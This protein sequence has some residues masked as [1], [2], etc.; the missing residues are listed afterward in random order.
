MNDILLHLQND[1]RVDRNSLLSRKNKIQRLISQGLT[2]DAEDFNVE[3]VAAHNMLKLNIIEKLFFGETPDINI[4]CPSHE[5]FG[6]E[7]KR[8]R[9]RKEDERD[10]AMFTENQ[11]IPVK[12]RTLVRYGYRNTNQY[13]WQLVVKDAILDKVKKLK[14]IQNCF[15]YL[16]SD[17]PY[18]IDDIV[19]KAGI[20]DAQ[21]S[22]NF[23][24]PFLGIFYQTIWKTNS[25]EIVIVPTSREFAKTTFFTNISE[26]DFFEIIE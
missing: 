18:Q 13:T 16:K 7:V 9:I 8:I 15:L 17:S 23:G 2:E 12:N 6:I 21:N 4:S 10:E 19:I 25:A 22:I 24:F 11:L 1:I 14:G 26:N 20:E 5:K 3:L